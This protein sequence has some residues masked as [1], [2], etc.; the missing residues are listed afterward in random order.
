MFAAAVPAIIGG[1]ASAGQAIFGAKDLKD[2]KAEL[3]RLAPA[4][5]KVQDEYYGNYNSAAEMAGSGLTAASK[6]FYSDMAGR[7]LGSAI[8]AVSEAGGSPNDIAK[9][10]DS[11]NTSIR[12]M[13]I[14]DSER[15]IGN[16]KYFQQVGK[17][18]AGQKTQQ[19]AINEYAPYQNKLKE[20]TA[21]IAADKQNIWG[22]IMG[23]AGAAQAGV[24][25][26]QNEKLLADLFKGGDKEDNQNAAKLQSFRNS[27]SK[28]VKFQFPERQKLNLPD[29]NLLP[30]QHIFDSTI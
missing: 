13:G 29:P 1:V 17:E 23:V 8:G 18:L 22:G 4:F 5:Y 3:S 7:G 19:W 24:T 30:D 26:M 15:Q 28:D 2:D 11:Y 12:S 6:D 14:E 9:M 25:S 16:I 10:F 20:L 21:R 27:M